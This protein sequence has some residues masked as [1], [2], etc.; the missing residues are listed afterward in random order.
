MD[1][2]PD[3]LDVFAQAHSVV[4]V[5]GLP[6]TKNRTQMQGKEGGESIAHSMYTAHV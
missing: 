4:P 1:R 3:T 2:I 5:L 6:Q